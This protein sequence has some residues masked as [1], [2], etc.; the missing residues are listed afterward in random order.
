MLGLGSLCGILIP[1]DW[2]RRLTYAGA[3]LTN[4]LAAFVLLSASRPSVYLSGTVLHMITEGFYWARFT[5]LTVEFVWARSCAGCIA[6]RR[7]HG[8]GCWPAGKQMPAAELKKLR[9]ALDHFALSAEHRSQ[10][11]E[12]LRTGEAAAESKGGKFVRR[13]GCGK[14]ARWKSPKK[15]LS[16]ALGNPA[17]RRAGFPLSHSHYGG[18]SVTSLMSR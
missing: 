11:G 2:D 1:G 10:A 5:A 4:A 9:Y 6:R 7:R 17:K 3:G 14:T 18:C 16:P 15:R 13:D 8:S 12:Y